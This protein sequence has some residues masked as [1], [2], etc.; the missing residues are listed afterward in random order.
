MW[1]PRKNFF[2][3]PQHDDP[4]GRA[5]WRVYAPH[6]QF[7]IA[8]FLF[9]LITDPLPHAQQPRPNLRSHFDTDGDGLND[10]L[11]EKLL[12]QFAPKFMV[13]HTDFPMSRLSLCQVKGQQRSKLR[14]AQSR[15]TGLQPPTRIP[16]DP[17]RQPEL[18]CIDIRSRETVVG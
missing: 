7:D 10:A 18:I 1:N 5:P 12:V 3:P 13:S 4:I 6:F 17:E 14:T 2:I 15:F 9:H 8:L 16:S 11:E